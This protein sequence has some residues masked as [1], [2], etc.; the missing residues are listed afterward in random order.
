MSRRPTS[1]STRQAPP[2]RSTLLYLEDQAEGIGLA[3]GFVDA[4]KDLVLFHAAEL[5]SLIKLARRERP[6]VL[7][8]NIDLTCLAPRDLV[9]RLRAEPAMQ[10]APVL[11]LGTDAKP[12]VITQ[13]LEAGVFLYLAKPLQAQPFMEALAFALEFAAVEQAE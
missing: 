3:R 1:R 13:S 2:K 10:H 9:K 6:E 8:I 5:E 7:L 11:A 12:S 4:R